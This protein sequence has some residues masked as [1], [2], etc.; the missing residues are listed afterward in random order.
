[1][2]DIGTPW[3]FLFENTVV[4]LAVFA[5]VSVGVILTLSGGRLIETLGGIFRIFLT[6][7]TTPFVFLRDS[8][9]LVRASGDAEQDYVKS[10]VFVLYRANR[11][12]YMALLVLCLLTLS[13][14][15]THA[16]LSLYPGAELQQSRLLGEQINQIEAEVTA[17]NEA[18]AA[19]ASPGNAE[20]LAAART[21]AQEAYERQANENL[22]FLQSTTFTG[23]AIDQLAGSRSAQS[24]QNVRVNIEYYMQGCPRQWR[25]MTADQCV[26]YR[27]F[28]TELADR[29][30][31]EFALADAAQVAEAAWRDADNASQAAAARLADAQAR[32]TYTQDQRASINPFNP[33]RMAERLT[34]SIL[35]VLGTLW[36]VI[37][38]VWAGAII[39]DVFNW[40][41]LMMRSLER[42]Q[43]A[44][45]VSLRS[46]SGGES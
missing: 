43:Q 12:W 26:Q 37:V 28:L 5:L 29:R 17:A 20:R 39:I 40:L 44:K 7:F 34:A 6:I 14:G 8:I 23:P 19:A 10:T 31:R 30:D 13:G 25:N 3:A 2:P 33:Q 24:V 45:L 22:T 1:M 4:G 38:T 42:T 21:Q 16:V 9:A 15:V 32:L 46:E 36:A 18:V 11:I 27:A 41:L 35:T